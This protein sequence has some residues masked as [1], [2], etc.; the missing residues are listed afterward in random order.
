MITLERFYQCFKCYEILADFVVLGSVV[1]L[2]WKQCPVCGC[3]Y[4]IDI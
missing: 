3:T 1:Y 2:G 4:R